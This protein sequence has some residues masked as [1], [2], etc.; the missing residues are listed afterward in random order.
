MTFL[1]ELAR[2]KEKATKG[3]WYQRF[4][5]ATITQADSYLA[6]YLVNHADAIEALVKAM[7]ALIDASDENMLFD[8]YVRKHGI[9]QFHAIENANY[10]LA[11]LDAAGKEKA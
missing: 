3:L 2:L 1:T 4:F 6:D 5:R 10:A 7:S 8:E 9:S 11:A